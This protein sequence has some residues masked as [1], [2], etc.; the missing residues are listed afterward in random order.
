MYCMSFCND[1]RSVSWL[2]SSR[3]ISSNFL[4]SSSVSLTRL[5]II[6]ADSFPLR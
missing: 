4:R 6:A 3:P 2:I 1:G 5:R